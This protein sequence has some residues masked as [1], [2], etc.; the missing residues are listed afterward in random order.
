MNI[1]IVEPGV[2]ADKHDTFPA[3]KERLDTGLDPV[4]GRFHQREVVHQILEWIC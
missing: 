1:S 2:A 4:L 3:A